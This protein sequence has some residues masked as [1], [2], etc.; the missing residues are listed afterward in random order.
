MDKMDTYKSE[1]II[2]SGNIEVDKKRKAETNE[3]FIDR[4]FLC[5]AVETSKC[6]PST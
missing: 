3:A 5:R 1:I 4:L 2:G 6:V